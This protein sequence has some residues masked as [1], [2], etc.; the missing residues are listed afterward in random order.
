MPTF[1]DDATITIELK[2]IRE[3][4]QTEN[5][6]GILRGSD[7]LLK[8]QVVAI[9]AHY[10]HLGKSKDGVI[11]PGAD[12]DGSGTA[13]VLELA[14]AFVK[15]PVKPKYSLL[16]MT[17]AGE[18]KGLLGSQ[19]YVNHPFIPLNRIIADL[20][21]DMIGRI[22]TV[23]EA[24]KDTNYIY[25]IGSDKISPELDS[26]L[27]V[28]NEESE[29]LELDHQYNNEYESEQLYRR[30]DHYNFAKNGIPIVFFFDGFHADYHKP[31]D[32]V[33]KILFNRIKRI[34]HLIYNLG[35]KLANLDQPLTKKL[36]E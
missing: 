6:A 23:Y 36:I 18:E 1:I 34:G 13:T 9:T 24:R 20:N 26:L 33:D 19:Y 3:T 10:D 25:V 22:D 30:S 16:F 11:Y 31:T 8:N 2:I 29:N 21:I 35:W 27:L 32:T 17:V 5:V 14:E 15:N 28:A 12:D 7:P 4:R